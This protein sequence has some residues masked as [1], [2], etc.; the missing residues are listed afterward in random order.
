L[1]VL[2]VDDE[3]IARRVLF[4]ELELL[5][6]IELVGQAENGWEALEKIAEL[7]PDLVFLDI[8]MPLMDGLEVLRNL[9]GTPLPLVVIVTAFDRHTVQATELGAFD[10]LLKPVDETTL[11]RTVERARSLVPAVSGS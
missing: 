2:I 8:Q 6:G 4:E 7:K 1:K 3:P 10:C 11:R 9:A 5:P